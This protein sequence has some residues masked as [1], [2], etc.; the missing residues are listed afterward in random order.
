MLLKS[1]MCDCYAAAVA[2]QYHIHA[3]VLCMCNNPVAYGIADT[4]VASSYTF[5]CA[6][7]K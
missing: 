5:M 1:L 3:L 2:W 4:G 7:Y 6:C